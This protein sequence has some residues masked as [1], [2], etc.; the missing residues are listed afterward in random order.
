MA[1]SVRGRVQHGG[2]PSWPP[3]RLRAL[4]NGLCLT[5]AGAV[6][7]HLTWSMLNFRVFDA[8]DTA[9]ILRILA[10]WFAVALPV[11]CVSIGV[12]MMLTAVTAT[13][14]L[15]LSH[16]AAAWDP[17]END[18]VLRGVRVRNWRPKF[19]TE[20]GAFSAKTLGWVPVQTSAVLAPLIVGF[21]VAVGFMIWLATGYGGAALTVFFTLAWIAWRAWR[22]W[23]ALQDFR[24]DRLRH[25]SA[26]QSP[27]GMDSAD[28]GG[29]VVVVTADEAWD[30]DDEPAHLPP[31]HPDPYQREQQL[32]LAMTREAPGSATNDVRVEA[33][34]HP[35]LYAEDTTDL[36]PVY[37]DPD[38]GAEYATAGETAPVDPEVPGVAA[39]QP[40]KPG[41]RRGRAQDPSTDTEADVIL[42]DRSAERA[43][44][45]RMRKSG[46]QTAGDSRP[47]GNTR[48]D[49]HDD[50]EQHP[51]ASRA[52]R[53]RGRKSP[54]RKQQRVPAESARETTNTAQLRTVRRT[55]APSKAEAEREIYQRRDEASSIFGYFWRR[56]RDD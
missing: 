25:A 53:G 7:F 15:L 6:L 26:A 31:A 34:Q 10:I 56:P 41:R 40:R 29:R 13:D 51:G 3:L 1:R 32:R 17:G 8:H 9:M 45:A 43:R 27:N 47:R 14:R 44:Q 28:D 20:S 24:G 21:L 11:G 38:A 5:L 49:R 55:G 36:I 19:G 46:A 35:D 37:R 23:T 12:H 54:T 16:G 30:D 33:T 4:I 52:G 2:L 18:D 48:H 50:A 42:V 39:R 22:A